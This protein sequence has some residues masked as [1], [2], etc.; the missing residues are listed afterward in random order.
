MKTYKY[1][2][3]KVG[4][5]SITGVQKARNK[6]DL[7]RILAKEN[8]ILLS[9]EEEGKKKPLEIN[10]SLKKGVPLTERMIFSR[11]LSVMIAAGFPF[12]KSLQVLEDQ[13]KNQNLKNA[14]KDIKERVVKGDSFSQA[15]TFHKEIFNDLYI[16]MVRIGEETGNLK[17]VLETL[18]D[19]MKKDHDI[20]GKVKGALMYPAVIVVLMAIIGVAMMTFVLPKFSKVFNDMG[21]QVPTITKII[22]SAGDY[23]SKYWYFIPITIFTVVFLFLR[24]KKTKQG[25]KILDSFYMKIPGVGSLLIMLNTARTARILSSLIKSGVPIVKSLEI[26]STTITNHLYQ[27]AVKLAAKEI[28]KGKTLKEALLPHSKIYSYLLIQMIEVGEETGNMGEV[29]EDL[30][31]FYEGEVDTV[32]KNLSS[33]IEP[34]IMVVIGIAVAVFAISIVQPMYSMMGSIK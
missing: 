26:L 22:L 29:L 5:E 4:G 23:L 20:R 12:D 33:I 31:E 19:Q 7:A 3:K 14:I 11:H 15:L 25:K 24:F 32:T 8:Y 6:E 16:N 30:A 17:E 9:A 28:Q 2:A 18:A 27:K 13:T 21:I 1:K 10:I 34:A